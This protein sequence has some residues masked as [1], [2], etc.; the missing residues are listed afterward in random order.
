MPYIYKIENQINHKV[1]IGKTVN[2]VEY[3]WAQHQREAVLRR[4]EQRPLYAAIAKY[5]IE[6]FV[7]ETLEEC[8]LDSL[9]IRECYWISVFDS[10]HNGYNATLGGDGRQ[11]ADYDLIYNLY[12]GGSDYK[13]I[14]SLTGYD[15][16]TIK[17]A[18]ELHGI[19]QEERRKRAF[20]RTSR[21]VARLD[22]TT[23]EILEILSSVNE[24][25]KKYKTGKH[26]ADVC[27]GKRK[28]AGGYG[29]K[30]I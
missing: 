20:A 21:R 18:L 30:Y 22:K 28:S 7:V 5:G 16:N 14:T 19:L 24:A 6:N 23:G 26:V 11:Y 10:Y 9:S 4:V 12:S 8:D 13:T 17:T 1:Y 25:D 2:S 15:K 27:K 3:R 29:W